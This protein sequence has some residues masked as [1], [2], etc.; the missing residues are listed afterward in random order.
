MIIHIV[1]T[2]KRELKCK[3]IETRHILRALHIQLNNQLHT[4][5]SIILLGS[6]N[7]K[8]LNMLQG[9]LIFQ[10]TKSPNPSADKL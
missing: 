9:K 4:A 5:A 10:Q 6:S 7:P 8:F 2:K 1:K 3:C